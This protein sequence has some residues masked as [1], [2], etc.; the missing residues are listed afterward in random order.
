MSVHAVAQCVS[1]QYMVKPFIVFV[2]GMV[3]VALGCFEYIIDH[4]R[5]LLPDNTG[6]PSCHNQ[7]DPDNHNGAKRR[8]VDGNHPDHSET[9]RIGVS[10]P[11]VL[12]DAPATGSATDFRHSRRTPRSFVDAIHVHPA[13]FRNEIIAASR[14]DDQT[15]SEPEDE[16]IL[17]PLPSPQKHNPNHVTSYTSPK[18]NNQDHRLG[19]WHAAHNCTS[20]SPHSKLENS[21]AARIMSAW[22]FGDILSN[23]GVTISALLIWKNPHS[24]FEYLDTALSLVISGAIFAI[25]IPLIKQSARPLLQ[26]NPAGMDTDEI[27]GDIEELPR[28]I[29]VHHLHVWQLSSTSLIAS[30][31]VQVDCDIN[32]DT[33]ASYMHLARQIRQCLHAHGIH[34]STIQPEFRSMLPEDTDESTVVEPHGS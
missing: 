4:M 29:F 27:K 18:E 20:L 32:G 15:E 7:E 11:T 22:T 2:I 10:T 23:V 28:V 31:H 13:S 25:T 12:I 34:S 14:L 19:S 33:S 9:V 5:H 16:G 3:G 24:G 1:L 17:D 21:I 30:L 26:A 6:H 8:P